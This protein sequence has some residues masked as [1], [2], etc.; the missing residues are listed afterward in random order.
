MGPFNRQ[1]QRHYIEEDNN[2]NNRGRWTACVYYFIWFYSLFLCEAR[3]I[4]PSLLF[5]PIQAIFSWVGSVSRILLTSFPLESA[6]SIP[7]EWRVFAICQFLLDSFSI[8]WV[9]EF[10]MCRTHTHIST[11]A[12]SLSATHQYQRPRDSERRQNNREATK[13]T[14][15]E[16][17]CKHGYVEGTLSSS[18]MHNR[19]T[20]CNI[21]MHVRL[22]VPSEIQYVFIHIYNNILHAS[23]DWGDDDD[24][25][26]VWHLLF[27]IRSPDYRSCP[28]GTIDRS[29]GNRMKWKLQCDFKPWLFVL[30]W[31]IFV[32]I[33]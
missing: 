17:V 6:L 27:D 20:I 11:L 25:D 32:S 8:R 31:K 22:H 12:D 1:R 7:N 13:P 29:E 5:F 19:S 16:N 18:C 3:N 30:L 24:D 21:H 2:S 9:R 33:K 23:V 10:R 4:R 15:L 28:I 14:R 26:S